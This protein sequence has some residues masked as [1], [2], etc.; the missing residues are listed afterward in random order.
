MGSVFHV[1]KEE[2]KRLNEAKA[3]YE[4]TIAKE[5]KG[6]PQIKHVGRKDY[7]Y[8]ARRVGNKIKYRYVGHLDSEASRRVLD[9]V[10]KRREYEKLLKGIKK[11]IKEVRRALRG[12]K[13]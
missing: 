5:E 6:S 1:I 11:D 2:R 3:A 9:S 7:L 4:I 13:T 8:L 12:R 10:K